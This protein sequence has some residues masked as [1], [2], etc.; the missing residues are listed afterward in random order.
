MHAGL[1]AEHV[2]WRGCRHGGQPIAAAQAMQCLQ[3][4]LQSEGIRA[5]RHTYTAPIPL[6]IPLPF[7]KMF[8]SYLT[9]DGD[10]VRSQCF[11]TTR[12]F[13]I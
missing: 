5:W 2:T 3:G 1:L 7:P 10:R 11:E 8:P 12:A 6:P 9:S 4:S 13:F